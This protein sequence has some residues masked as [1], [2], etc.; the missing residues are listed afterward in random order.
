M[1]L[2]L[3]QVRPRHVDSTSS[4]SSKILR[5]ISGGKA[6]STGSWETVPAV[7]VSEGPGAFLRNRVMTYSVQHMMSF[8]SRWRFRCLL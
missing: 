5:W 1:E 4:R 7:I 8:C 6:V 3:L 2:N